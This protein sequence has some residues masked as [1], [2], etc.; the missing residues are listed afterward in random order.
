M[1]LVIEDGSGVA[2]ANSYVTFQDYSDW[3]TARGITLEH[4]NQQEHIEQH[5]IRAMDYFENLNFLGRKATD[6]QPLQ[7]PRT[8]VVIDSYSVN[9]DTIP[10]QVKNAVYEIT[11]SIDDGDFYLD[12][13]SRETIKEK[14]GDLEVT[15][16]STTGMK[17]M[18]PSITTALKKITVSVDAVSRA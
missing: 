7:W 18:T 17:R 5:I 1:A 16:S 14:V 10:Q 13:V 9:S 2:G 4:V 15:Y 11:K 3:A 8:E 6:T 12:P